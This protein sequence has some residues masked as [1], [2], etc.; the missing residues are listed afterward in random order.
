MMALFLVRAPESGFRGVFWKG[1]N[2]SH[3]TPSMWITSPEPKLTFRVS[4]VARTEI[5]LREISISGTT[6]RARDGLAGRASG[7]CT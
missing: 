2:N 3:R 5:G 4:W 7:S 6:V 1:T